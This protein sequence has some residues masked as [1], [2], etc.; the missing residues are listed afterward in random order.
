MIDIRVRILG[1][2]D[3]GGGFITEEAAKSLVARFEKKPE[4][5]FVRLDKSPIIIGEVSK[6]EYDAKEKA[7]TAILLMSLDFTTGGRILQSLDTPQGKRVLDCELLAI[8][9]LLKPQNIEGVD[10][11]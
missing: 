10:K 1:V 4:K 11:K 8:N 2:G 5:M 9:A 6:L 7:V 3:S